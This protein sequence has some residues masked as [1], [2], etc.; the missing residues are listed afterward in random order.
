MGRVMSL[1][2]MGMAVAMIA[3]LTFGG[4]LTDLFGVRQVIAGGAVILI[5]A[6][7]LTLARITSTPAPRQVPEPIAAIEVA[8]PE[9]APVAR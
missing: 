1:V 5:A 9:E 3:S 7:L 8:P 6:G 4:V 2:N